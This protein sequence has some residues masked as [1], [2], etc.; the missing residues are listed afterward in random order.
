GARCPADGSQDASS[1]DQSAHR[2]PQARCHL[3]GSPVSRNRPGEPSFPCEK[4][5]TC[6]TLLVLLLL[7]GHGCR[8]R[9]GFGLI[10]SVRGVRGWTFCQFVDSR[11][12]REP[13]E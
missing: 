6:P 8:A 12:E 4:S 9:T 11:K 7:S 13:R 2:D 5:L 3:R 10:R 1:T